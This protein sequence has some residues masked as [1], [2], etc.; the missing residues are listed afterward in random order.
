MKQCKDCEF[1]SMGDDGRRR[2]LCDPFGNIIEPECVGKWQL[3]RLDTLVSLIEEQNLGSR[4]I[5]PIQEKLIRY[6]EREIEEMEEGED[7]KY[8]QDED[9]DFF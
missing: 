5:A 6:V 3:M 2:F 8:P 1:Y 4:K 9:D 7:W